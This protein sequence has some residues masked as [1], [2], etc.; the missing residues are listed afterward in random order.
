MRDPESE[1]CSTAGA[2]G[3]IRR[4][5]GHESRPVLPAVGGAIDRIHPEAG[6]HDA[7]VTWIEGDVGRAV[8]LAL[9]AL[10]EL[11]LGAAV[12]RLPDPVLRRIGRRLAAAAGAAAD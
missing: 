2:E 9:D 4:D 1:P 5:A 10:H 11:P 3:G 8:E 7:R 6:I 12:G